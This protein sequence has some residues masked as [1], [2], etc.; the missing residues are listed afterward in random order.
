MA[1]TKEVKSF[2]TSK[3]IYLCR[4]KEFL[5]NKTT[6]SERGAG[7]DISRQRHMHFGNSLPQIVLEDPVLFQQLDES[8]LITS[9]AWR[10]HSVEQ[11]SHAGISGIYATQ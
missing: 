2:Y 9:L 1:G 3:Q 4:N 11:A 6:E 7:Q 5:I 10:N 8:T